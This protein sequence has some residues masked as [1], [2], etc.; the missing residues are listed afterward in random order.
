VPKTGITASEH[1]YTVCACFPCGAICAGICLRRWNASEGQLA[2]AA[3]HYFISFARTLYQKITTLLPIGVTET[4]T[5][6]PTLLRSMEH[7]D[8]ATGGFL[9]AI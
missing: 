2:S 1:R 6:Q 4:C 5:E 3:A 7:A 8:I 9:I